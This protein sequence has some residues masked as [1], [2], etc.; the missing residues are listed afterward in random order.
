MTDDATRRL[1]RAAD[2]GDEEARYVLGAQRAREGRCPWCTGGDSLCR[3]C[4][5]MHIDDEQSKEDM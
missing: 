1:E 2:Q 4:P 5:A 3:G